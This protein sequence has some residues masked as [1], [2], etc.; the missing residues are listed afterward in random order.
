MIL[1]AAAGLLCAPL[2]PAA[3]AGTTIRASVAS[4]GTQGNDWSSEPS[5]SADGRCVA[6]Q[7]YADNLVSD[8]TNEKADV[9]V[10]DTGPPLFPPDPPADPEER[11][12]CLLNAP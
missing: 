2:R 5:I 8:N 11:F 7:S 10:H 12:R 3:L 1:V 6:F 4:N 9:L